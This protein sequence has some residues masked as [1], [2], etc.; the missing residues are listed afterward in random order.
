MKAKPPASVNATIKVHKLASK[1]IN[2]TPDDAALEETVPAGA[3][4]GKLTVTPGNWKGAVAVTG[5]N[6]GDVVVTAALEVRAARE[7]PAGDYIAT[8]TADP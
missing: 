6:A 1:A 5:P 8:F 3:L 4:L 2:F 7:L